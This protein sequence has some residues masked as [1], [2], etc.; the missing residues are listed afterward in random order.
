MTNVTAIENQVQPT[1][2]DTVPTQ[3]PFLAST[4]SHDNASAPAINNNDSLAQI[5]GALSAIILLI[6]VGAWLVKKFG[7]GRNTFTKQQLVNVKGRCTIGGKE[8]IVVVEVNSEYLVLGVTA[9]SVNLLHQ[10]PAPQENPLNFTQEPLT[11]QSI[12]KKKQDAANQAAL[13][14]Q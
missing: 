13:E 6:L 9:Q 1:V 2:I 14:K 4:V 3:K 11:F 8:R 7:F 5:S 12:F 10:Y